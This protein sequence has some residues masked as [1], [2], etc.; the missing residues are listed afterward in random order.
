VA[1]STKTTVAK[2]VNEILTIRLAGAGFAEIVQY[3]AEKGWGVCERQLRNYVQASDE[4]LAADLET[5]RPK[6]M[7][8]HLAQRRLL[9]NKTMEVGDYAA[10]LRVLDSAAKLQDLYPSKQEPLD[11]LLNSLPPGIAAAVRAELARLVPGGAGAEGGGSGGEP[12]GPLQPGSGGVHAPASR[13]EPV[14]R[15]G[16]DCPPTPD[17]TVPRVGEGQP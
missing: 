17:A 15:A 3:A 10:A 16:T 9:L 14:G 13:V 6:L 5:A 4:L 8:M 12:A 1:K 11:A 2:R 7:A